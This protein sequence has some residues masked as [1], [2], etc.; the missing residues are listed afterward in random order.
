MAIP[1]V[2]RFAAVDLCGCTNN[3]LSIIMTPMTATQMDRIVTSSL[4]LN[5]NKRKQT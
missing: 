1:S 5:N 2:T 3:A 4:I